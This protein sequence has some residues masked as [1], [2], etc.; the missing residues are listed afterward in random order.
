MVQIKN[1]KNVM[2]HRPIF[3]GMIIFLISGLGW[4]VFVILSV[5]TLGKLSWIANSF[6][7]VASISLPTAIMWEI[8]KRI[9]N[10]KYHGK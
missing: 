6:G 1:L 3:W 10:R 9:K 5:V 4:F 2:A 8:V 7:V